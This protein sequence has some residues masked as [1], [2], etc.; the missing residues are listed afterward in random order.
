M[1]QWAYEMNNETLV[2]EFADA[3]AKAGTACSGLVIDV[4][5]PEYVEEAQYLK[6][7]LLARLDGL[8]PP[9]KRDDTVRPAQKNIRAVDWWGGVLPEKPSFKIVRIY[10]AGKG[11]WLLAFQGIPEGD[12]GYPKFDTLNFVLDSAVAAV[13]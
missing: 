6:G 10:Y 9:F 12:R 13:V 8:K 1:S 2:K 7:V 4:R 11:Q 5:G 3:C